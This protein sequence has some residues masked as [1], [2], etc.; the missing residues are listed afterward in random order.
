[1]AV[2]KKTVPLS[3]LFAVIIIISTLVII[4][5]IGKIYH[6]FNR[7]PTEI[8]ID[9]KLA[10][11]GESFDSLQYDLIDADEAPA[12]L[13]E[14]VL[15]GYQIMTETPKYAS[16][17][18][19]DRLSCTNCHFNGGN[20]TGGK[21]GSISLAGIAAAYPAYNK[22]A[23]SV[24]TLP[25]RINGC[26]LRSM[27]GKALPLDS[28]EM[29]ALVTYFHWISK[30]FPI[31]EKIPW[32][33]LEPIASKHQPSAENGAGVYNEKCAPCHGKEG[34]GEIRIPP[35]WG[36]S[37]FNGGAGMHKLEILSAFIYHNMPYED[38]SLTEEEAL[39]VAAFIRK[40]KRPDF[41]SN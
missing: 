13:K 34:Q 33:G 5:F 26:F 27:N 14:A 39:D 28:K 32:R 37:S 30:N 15:F 2:N 41:Q 20:T 7:S 36:K 25:E 19:G 40:Q 17:Y 24:V 12:D 8:V 11:E 16:A 38:P 31:Y 6:Y 21:N 4:P 22:R 10:K 1:M 3:W 23:D 35:L 29:N 18:T 9:R